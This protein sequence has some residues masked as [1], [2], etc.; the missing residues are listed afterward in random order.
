MKTINQ[1]KAGEKEKPLLEKKG[2]EKLVNPMIP[3][4]QAE[5][6][7]KPT[8]GVIEEAVKELNPDRNSMESRG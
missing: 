4:Q 2:Y 3:V 8:E 7:R 1:V 6:Y 5:V